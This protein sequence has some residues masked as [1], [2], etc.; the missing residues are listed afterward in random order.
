MLGSD[1][2]KTEGVNGKQRSLPLPTFGRALCVVRVHSSTQASWSTCGCTFTIRAFI[3]FS[4]T[5][6]QYSGR[7]ALVLVTRRCLRNT[8]VRYNCP[9]PQALLEQEAAENERSKASELAKDKLELVDEL[10]KQLVRTIDALSKGISKNMMRSHLG[11]HNAEKT[12]RHFA[13]IMAS[14]FIKY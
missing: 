12:K 2:G 3:V 9:Y 10:Q 4:H 14:S 11:A 6:A 1:T 5:A 8:G 13:P 7:M